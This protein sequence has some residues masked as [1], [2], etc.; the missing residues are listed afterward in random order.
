MDRTGEPE[1]DMK[2]GR[3]DRPDHPV[4]GQPEAAQPH[5][6]VLPECQPVPNHQ[7]CHQASRPVLAVVRDAIASLVRQT[8]AL[9]VRPDQRVFLEHRA[10]MVWTDC[11]AFLAKRRLM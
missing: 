11:P 6:V 8:N 2:L 9:L 5:P 10:K 4:A 3:E 1:L 7:V